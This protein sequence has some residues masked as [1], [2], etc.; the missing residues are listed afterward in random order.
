VLGAI[1]AAGLTLLVARRAL[2]HGDAE[3]RHWYGRHAGTG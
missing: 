2:Q 3:L 1:V